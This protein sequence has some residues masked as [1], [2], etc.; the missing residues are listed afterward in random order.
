VLG[1][2]LDV[3]ESNHARLDRLQLFDHVAQADGT[4]QAQ[5][6]VVGGTESG[7]GFV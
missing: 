4:V 7:V 6:G 2:P 3:H 5:R 1:G